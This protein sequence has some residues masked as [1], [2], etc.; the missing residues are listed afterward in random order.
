[1]E[2]N[3]NERLPF[4]VVIASDGYKKLI[5]QT[6]GDANVARQFV[7]DIS[8]VV[9]NNPTI[10]ECEP[11]TIITAGLVAASLKLPLAGNLGFAHIVPY[12]DKKTGIKK[13]QFQVG[14]KGF[15]QLSQRSG[16]FEK[17]GSRPVHKSEYKGQDEFGDD[18]FSFSHEYDNEEI[19]G[20]YAYLKLLNGFVKTLYMTK[21]QCE[22]HAAK[23]SSSYKFDRDKTTLW[24]TEFDT[25][26]QKTVIKLLLSRYAPLSVD[27]QTA[28]KADQ[29]VIN[30][31]GTY[32]YVENEKTIKTNVNNSLAIADKKEDEA[33]EVP[34]EIEE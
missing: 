34:F 5:N 31:D 12:K 20:Y 10:R 21:E 1:M 22:K 32:E 19:I 9:A 4:S 28:I 26:A 29:A 2:N 27:M 23:Y 3:E 13:A 11:A 14:W 8:A 24:N 30:T 6:L 16:S 33:F 7:A 18:I 17:I 25:M 15:V